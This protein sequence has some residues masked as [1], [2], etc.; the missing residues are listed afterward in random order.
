MTRK[1]GE[2]GDE[3]PRRRRRRLVSTAE[4]IDFLEYLAP[5]SLSVPEEPYGLQVGAPTS[6]IKT[7]VVAPMA[8]FNALSTAASRKQSMLLT[9][10]ALITKPLMSVRRDEPIGSKLSYLL[11]HRINLYSLANS[12]ASAPGGF[13]DSLAERLGLAAT[14]AL[15]PTAYEQQYKIAVYTPP[16]AVE[17]VLDAATEAGAG[18]IGNYSHCSFQTNGIGTFLPRDGARPTIGSLGR[19]EKVDEV[20]IEMLVPQREMKGVIAAVLD[21]HPYEEVAYDVYVVKNP[22]VLY[23]RGRIGELPLQVSLETVLAQVQDS[24]EADSVRCSHRP[25]FPIG[26][27]AAASGASDDLFWHANRA[28]AGALITGGTSVQDLMLADNSTTVVVDI[29]YAASVAPGLKRLCIQL[30]NTFGA[31]GLE[32]IYSG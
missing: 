14:S 1:P 24:L 7:V 11:E 10:A 27:L 3:R 28:G 20:R 29:G 4:I 26:M 12:Y 17:K 2:L 8:S 16:A 18:A 21:A 5:P 13:D 15:I 22:G 9:A 25:D 23:G 32:V 19:L 31:D 30:R 6:E